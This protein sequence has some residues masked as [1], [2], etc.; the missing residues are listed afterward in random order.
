VGTADGT[1]GKRR[2]GAAA[3]RRLM[4]GFVFG[5]A[6]CSALGFACAADAGSLL[7]FD[8][9]SLTA[10][11][12]AG[13]DTTYSG[14]VLLASDGNSSFEDM[15]IDGTAQSFGPQ[16]SLAAFTGEVTFLNGAI[17]GGSFMVS[18]T[19]GVATDRYAADLVEGSGSIAAQA[20]QGYLVSGLSFEGMF[21]GSTFA[22]IDVSL[23]HDAEPLSGSFLNFAFAPDAQGVDTDS[24]YE[25]FVEAVVIPLPAGA[26]LSAAGLLGFAGLRRRAAWRH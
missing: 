20:G 1:I 26:G 15:R 25:I 21:S 6:A 14:S 16:W 9:N 17:T 4:H 11:A 13:F 24:D 19:D 23:W 18:V 7:R 10:S 12:D 22:G 3:E 5:L 2:W 8:V